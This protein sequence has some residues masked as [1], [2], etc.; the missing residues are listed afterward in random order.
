MM[1]S[2]VL[3][4][5]VNTMFVLLS[6]VLNRYSGQ[7]LSPPTLARSIKSKPTGRILG[8]DFKLNWLLNKTNMLLHTADFQSVRLRTSTLVTLRT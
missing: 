2:T 3:L 1:V 5:V 4:G 7:A 8:M 6:I